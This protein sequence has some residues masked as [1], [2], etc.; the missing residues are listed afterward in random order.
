MELPEIPSLERIA[1]LAR[2]NQPLPESLRVKTLT[3]FLESLTPQEYN[4]FCK[5]M[6]SSIESPQRKNGSEVE[7]W[8]ECRCPVLFQDSR[9]KEPEYEGSEGL[10]AVNGGLRK[11][12]CPA[13]HSESSF[14]GKKT[15]YCS[16]KLQWSV[17]PCVILEG[18]K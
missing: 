15:Y 14:F 11:V 9:K 3:A 16:I 8:V 18:L 4:N 5:N 17:E 6:G 1:S 10:I 2:Q 7:H 12:N 13:L